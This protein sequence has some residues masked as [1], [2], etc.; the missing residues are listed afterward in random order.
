M[1]T[2]SAGAMR[3]PQPIRVIATDIDGTLL[4][5]A[6]RIPPSNLRAL[7]RA[8]ERGVRLVL[9]TA[10][11]RSSALAIAEA[12]DL[13]CA[14]VAHNG[15][16]AWDWDGAELRHLTVDLALARSIAEFAEQH[17]LP[18]IMT[19][20]E[21][22]YYDARFPVD[23]RTL[24]SDDRLV[25]SMRDVLHHP[26]T[27]IIVSGHAEVERLTAT[28]CDERDSIVIHRYYSREGALE[29]AVVTHPRA[30]KQDALADLLAR[31]RIAAEQVLTI[32][33][34]EADA[35]MLRWAGIGVAMGNA[36]PEARSAAD[37]VAPT[38]DQAGLAAAI[39]RFVLGDRGGS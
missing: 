10:R 24:R 25:S 26:P 3:A 15:A 5:S 37:W 21:I 29:S 30:T 17:A 39:D 7:H 19:I 35:G 4:D 20:D 6:N 27:R 23:P 12:L 32:G 1:S 14:C 9:A 33:D 18:L 36:M 16:R 2:P 11:K 34:A 22:N 28:Y 31:H 13:P 38:H 8:V